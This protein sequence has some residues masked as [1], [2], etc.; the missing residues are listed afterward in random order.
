MADSKSDSRDGWSKPQ[1]ERLP[2]RTYCPVVLALAT[3]FMFWGVVT[4]YAI[5]F[6]GI[7]LFAVAITGWVKELRH[8]V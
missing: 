1:P 4:S 8:G 6:A 7:I 5:S 2:E 3:I